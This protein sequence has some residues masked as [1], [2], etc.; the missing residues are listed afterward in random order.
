MPDKRQLI[1]SKFPFKVSQ[2]HWLEVLLE[3]IHIFVLFQQT[4][5]F[6]TVLRKHAIYGNLIQK[7]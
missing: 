5:M 3:H 2:K 4:Y 1:T 6:S 7:A